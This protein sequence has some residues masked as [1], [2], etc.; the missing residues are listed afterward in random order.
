MKRWLI[1]LRHGE[2]EGNVDEEVYKNTPTSELKLTDA[3]QLQAT[4]AGRS[5]VARSVSGR[6]AIFCS[7]F[8]RAL[9]TLD[10]VK[11]ELKAAGIQITSQTILDDLKEQK[12][13]NAAGLATIEDRKESRKKYDHYEYCFPQGIF[14]KSVVIDTWSPLT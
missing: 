9:D 2:S 1:F 5:I 13:G 8:D 7:S 3:G 14:S 4:S 11:S 6:V 12:Y 10:T